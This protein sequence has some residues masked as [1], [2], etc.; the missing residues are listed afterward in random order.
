MWIYQ[1][2]HYKSNLFG[3]DKLLDRRVKNRDVEDDIFVQYEQKRMD[4]L[5]KRRFELERAGGFNLEAINSL[6]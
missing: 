4:I 5:G 2:L 1:V 3:V 6:Q